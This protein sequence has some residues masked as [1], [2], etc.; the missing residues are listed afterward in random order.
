[1]RRKGTARYLFIM[2]LSRKRQTVTL[3]GE[4]ASLLG[5]DRVGTVLAMEPYGIEIV[6]LTE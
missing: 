6:E 5:E 3:E 1:M 2:N 4:Y